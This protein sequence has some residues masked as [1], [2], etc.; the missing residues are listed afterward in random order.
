MECLKFTCKEF[1][2]K[3][4][5]L[6]P[7]KGF[8]MHLQCTWRITSDKELLVGSLDLY[9]SADDSEFD[10]G[11]NWDRPGS[12]LRDRRLDDL[13]KSHE[14]VVQSAAADS[15]GGFKIRFKNGFTLETFIAESRQDEFSE[16]WRLIDNR[17]E[18]SKHFVLSCSTLKDGQYNA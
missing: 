16:H 10:E 3:R 1:D 15:F 7:P 12:N 6:N 5:Q 4:E 2:D 17:G 13:L 18:K 8:A 14:L 11:F 9:Q